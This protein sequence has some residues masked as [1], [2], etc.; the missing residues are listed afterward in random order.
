MERIF[1]VTQCTKDSMDT[2]YSEL[3]NDYDSTIVYITTS[4][5]LPVGRCVKGIFE[6]LP[7]TYMADLGTEQGLGKSSKTIYGLD[8]HSEY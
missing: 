5:P 2:F 7:E 6:L 8:N 4:D 3:T 1:T